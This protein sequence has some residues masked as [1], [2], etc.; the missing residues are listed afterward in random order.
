MRARAFENMVAVAV[1]NYAAPQEASAEE[2]GHSTLVDPIAFDAE[3]RSRDTRVFEAGEAE[4][5]CVVRLD[6][7]ALREWRRARGVGSQCRR[8]ETYGAL[9]EHGAAGAADA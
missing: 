2:N 8:P 4:D 9:V 7:D 3:G 5:V 6:L 1:A